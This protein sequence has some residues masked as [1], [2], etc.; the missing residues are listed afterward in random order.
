MSSTRVSRGFCASLVD[1]NKSVSS[2]RRERTKAVEGRGLGARVR[3][4]S[5]DARRSP[6]YIGLQPGVLEALCPQQEHP[7]HERA[8][9]LVGLEFQRRLLAHLLGSSSAATPPPPLPLKLRVC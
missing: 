3:G 4:E 6:T 2:C 8:D 9:V 7:S 1:E 5:A